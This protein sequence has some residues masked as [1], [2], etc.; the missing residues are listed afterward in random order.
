MRRAKMVPLAP[1]T[2]RITL[3]AREGS[4]EGIEGMLMS[5][6]REV[7]KVCVR[8]PASFGV[9]SLFETPVIPAKAGMYSA[10][11]RK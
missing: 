11:L 5:V 6:L 8:V 4:E 9:R 2:P 3:L 10:N 7:K 1:V